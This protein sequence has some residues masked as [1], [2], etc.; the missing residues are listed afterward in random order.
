MWGDLGGAERLLIIGGLVLVV[1]I[2]LQHLVRPRI[3]TAG[4]VPPTVSPM[5]APVDEDVRSLRHAQANH[6]ALMGALSNRMGQ[7]EQQ[8][9]AVRGTLAEIKS[10]QQ[11]TEH[12]VMLLLE[13]GL[14][15]D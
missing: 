8:V 11:R 5:V 13:Q 4:H 14:R 9:A 6:E 15:K 3:A 1:V 10:S 12:Q 7:Q 2:L